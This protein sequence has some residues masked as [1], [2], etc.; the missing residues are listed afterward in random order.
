MIWKAIDSDISTITSRCE[1][2]DNI[3][4]NG[5]IIKITSPD[6]TNF[7]ASLE[8]RQCFKNDGLISKEEFESGILNNHYAGY[9]AGSLF[10]IPVESSGN[11]TIVSRND[12]TT[13]FNTSR[14]KMVKGE[15]KNGIMTNVSAEQ[16]NEEFQKY[17]ST[18]NDNDKKLGGIWF[19]LNPELLVG[20][21]PAFFMF[22]AEGIIHITFG[23]NQDF[24]GSNTSNDG[25][26]YP[27]MDATVE[28]D[29]ELVFKDGKWV[30]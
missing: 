5:K 17:L 14:L 27:V 7:T 3:L 11:G 29:G 1:K 24:G 26:S 8:G 23:G 9:P 4:F 28:V 19:G 12:A 15:V 25:W 20:K 6:G 10:V 30:L 2:L 22:E 13:F 18:Q 16:G 21:D